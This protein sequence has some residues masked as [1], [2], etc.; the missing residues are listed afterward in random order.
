MKKLI[1]LAFAAAGLQMSIPQEAHAI[2]RTGENHFTAA[3]DGDAV[4]LAKSRR[5]QYGRSSAR[6]TAYR[7]RSSRKFYQ[8]SA[9]R[10]W[11]V[12]PFIGEPTVP[13]YDPW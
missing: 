10:S 4:L 9:R 7:G 12:R 8:G 1:V 5:G 3:S 6:R 13:A 11:R 2:M